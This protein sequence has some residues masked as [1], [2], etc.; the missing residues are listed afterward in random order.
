M[1]FLGVLNTLVLVELRLSCG[2]TSGVC[3]VPVSSSGCTLNIPHSFFCFSSGWFES[4]LYSDSAMLRSCMTSVP[5]PTR[6]A[7]GIFCCW[8]RLKPS[9]GLLGNVACSLRQRSVH[10]PTIAVVRLPP[11]SVWLK[12]TLPTNAA[13]FKPPP[14]ECCCRMTASRDSQYSQYNCSTSPLPSQ[15]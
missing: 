15:G 1:T 4:Q 12:A 3:V 10:L 14:P 6:K 9:W 13:S 8:Q 7:K 11:T 5:P 2:M